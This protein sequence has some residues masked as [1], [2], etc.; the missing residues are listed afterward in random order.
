M[1]TS[2]RSRP[3]GTASRGPASL[4]PYQPLSNPLN[5]DAIIA[6]NSFTRTYPLTPLTKRQEVAL[7]SLQNIAADI[8]E[9]YINRSI[10]HQRSTAKRVQRGAEEDQVQAAKIAKMGQD[11][12]EITAKMEE[13]VR[14]VVDSKAHTESVETALREMSV[15]LRESGGRSAPTQSTLGASQFRGQKRQ[16]ANADDDDEDEDEDDEEEDSELQSQQQ[17]G[18]STF[19]RTRLAASATSYDS[20]SL[21]DKYASNN[22]Y[23][24]FRKVLHDAQH[25]GEEDNAPP[26]PHASTWFPSSR[27]TT[28][29]SHN[30][31]TTAADASDED[32]QV[33]SEKRS[34]RCPITLRPMREPISSTKCPHSFEKAA[35]HDMLSA[36]SLTVTAPITVDNGTQLSMGPKRQKAIKCPECAIVL[37]AAN[38]KV[39]AALV[40]KIRRMQ[41]KEAARRDEDSD[42]ETGYVKGTQRQHI[43]SRRDAEAGGREVSVVPGTQLGGEGEDDSY[44]M[45]GETQIEGSEGEADVASLSE[46]GEEEEDE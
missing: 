25:A 23:I 20:L 13:A 9:R 10:T 39:D 16:R 46:K 26:M 2:S 30:A 3:S 42:G 7:S 41:A 17:E 12:K 35:I 43:S 32:I 29:D 4:P 40:R 18:P 8:N 14:G 1:A 31:T 28:H 37:T 27:N 15:N 22:D 45:V 5:Q 6:L 24:G 11:T 33:A 21:S 44:E 36:S 38:L 19:L 34:L